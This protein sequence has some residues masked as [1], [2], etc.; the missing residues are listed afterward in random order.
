MLL[1]NVHVASPP[2]ELSKASFRQDLLKTAAED[3]E[4][5]AAA[6]TQQQQQKSDSSGSLTTLGATGLRELLK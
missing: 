2:T 1:R 5:A 4:K 3:Q 6:A